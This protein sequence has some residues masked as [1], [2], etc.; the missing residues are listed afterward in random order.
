LLALAHKKSHLSVDTVGTLRHR[1]DMLV[2]TD[3]ALKAAFDAH[4][5]V[6]ELRREAAAA[7]ATRYDEFIA[8]LE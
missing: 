3:Q 2:S 6:V 1:E 7:R 8:A 4:P 5:A